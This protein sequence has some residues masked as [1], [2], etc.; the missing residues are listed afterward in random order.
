MAGESRW[1]GTSVSVDGTARR[2]TLS[3]AWRNPAGKVTLMSQITQHPTPPTSKPFVLGPDDGEH[4]WF[5]ATRMTIKATA[6]TTAGALGVVEVRA[7][8]GFSPP[9]HI[10]HLEDEAFWLLEG[11]LTLLCDGQLFEATTGSFIWL[12]RNRP[13]TFRVEGDTPVRMLELITPGEHAGFYAEGGHP[14]LDDS[15]PEFDPR[16]IPRLEGLYP[17]YGL[18]T[19]GPPLAPVDHPSRVDGPFKEQAGR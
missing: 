18:E 15:I 8:P 10:H 4:V 11:A 9:L 19:V 1:C 13:H 16:D 14:A 6:Q 12:P 5:L 7:A 17:K 3:I 2:V